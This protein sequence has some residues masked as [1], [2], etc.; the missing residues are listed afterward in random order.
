MP[1]QLQHVDTA[2]GCSLFPQHMPTVPKASKEPHVTNSTVAQVTQSVQ[3]E[4]Q[5]SFEND[6]HCIKIPSL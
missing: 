1:G 6:P 5:S 2:G 3:S 4:S